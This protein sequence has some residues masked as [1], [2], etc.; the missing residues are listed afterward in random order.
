MRL[1]Y[2]FACY[3]SKSTF[4]SSRV[5][6]RAVSGQMSSFEQIRHFH[7]QDTARSSDTF[8]CSYQTKR[9]DMWTR[10]SV[11]SRLKVF[12]ASAISSTLKMRATLSSETS[13]YNKPTRCHIPKDAFFSSPSL[14]TQEM[15]GTFVDWM[16]SSERSPC[17]HAH[18]IEPTAIFIYLLDPS[19]LSQTR[20]AVLWEIPRSH[21]EE[22]RDGDLLSGVLYSTCR[23]SPLAGRI[24]RALHWSLPRVNRVHRKSLL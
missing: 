8:V 16:Y 19:T 18:W 21:G 14:S 9:T 13:V 15:S 5:W 7:L 12:L 6:W 10:Q 3:I 2:F 17:E 22:W 20:I 1:N 4:P 24:H 11:S 23:W